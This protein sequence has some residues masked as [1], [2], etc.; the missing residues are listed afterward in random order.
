M[1]TRS[2]KTRCL[3]AFE[4][5]MPMDCTGYILKYRALSYAPSNWSH[6]YTYLAKRDIVEYEQC[7]HESPGLAC[8]EDPEVTVT[9]RLFEHCVSAAVKNP[10][11]S[12]LESLIEQCSHWAPLIL[13]DFIKNTK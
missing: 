10:T 11:S 9:A 13:A 12:Q 8:C 3:T 5:I 6:T 1:N 2:V 7:S 4:C